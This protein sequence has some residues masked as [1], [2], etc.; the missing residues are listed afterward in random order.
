MSLRVTPCFRCRLLRVGAWL[1]PVA[2]ASSLWPQRDAAFVARALAA[3]L[4]FYLVMCGVW[5][6]ITKLRAAHRR[7]ADQLAAKR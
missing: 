3:W 2:L 6:G 4:A 5:W 1:L 7:A